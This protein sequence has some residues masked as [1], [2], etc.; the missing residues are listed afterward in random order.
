ML[1]GPVAVSGL[2][3]PV[4]VERDALGVPT[5]RG[6]NRADVSRALGWVHAQDRFFSRWISCAAAVRGNSRSSWQRRACRST[7]RPGCTGFDARAESDSS[8]LTPGERAL[9][10]AYTAGVNAGL[11]ALAGKTV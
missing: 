9:V 7:A 3:A 4:T 2:T 5:I 8:G 11:A 6:A 10:D 1:E